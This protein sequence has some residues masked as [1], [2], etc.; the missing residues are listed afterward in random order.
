MAFSGDFTPLLH[1]HTVNLNLRDSIAVAV[2]RIHRGFGQ[3]NGQIAEMREFGLTDND[4]RLLIYRAFMERAIKGISRQMMPIVHRNYFEPA[5][6]DFSPRNLWSLSNAFTS[7]FKTLAPL[8]QFEATAKLGRYLASIPAALQGERIDSDD[9]NDS[10]IDCG[11]ERFKLVEVG[12]GKF[13][14]EL[15][16]SDDIDSQGSNMEYDDQDRTVDTV[17]RIIEETAVKAAA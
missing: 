6:D 5:H 1:K 14:E 8:K 13:K 12:D 4:A 2:D 11:T 7:A 9:V 17:D 16:G 3:I 10:L 15:I